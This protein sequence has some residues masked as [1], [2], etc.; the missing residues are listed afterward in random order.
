MMPTE[1]KASMRVSSE[2]LATEPVW[3]HMPVLL[4]IINRRHR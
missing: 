4:H 1:G 3:P 2:D